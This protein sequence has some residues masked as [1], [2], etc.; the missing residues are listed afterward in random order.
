MIRTAADFTALAAAPGV[1]TPLLGIRYATRATGVP[2]AETKTSE[3]TLRIGIA[4]SKKIGGAVVRNR[5]R[6]RLKVIALEL[7]TQVRPGTDLLIGVRAGAATAS[8]DQLRAAMVDC[9]R[10]AKLLEGARA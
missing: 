2:A 9:L 5:I 8:I 1:N 6:R 3:P 7:S 10:R 4:A